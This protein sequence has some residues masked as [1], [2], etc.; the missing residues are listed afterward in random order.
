MT[1][2]IGYS[3]A[4]VAIALLGTVSLFYFNAFSMAVSALLLFG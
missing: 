4:G 3:A 2:A 1:Q